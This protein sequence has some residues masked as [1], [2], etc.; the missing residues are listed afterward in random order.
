M[1]ATVPPRIQV[2]PPLRESWAAS[3]WAWGRTRAGS[4]GAPRMPGTVRSPPS[5]WCAEI[6]TS[7]G[8]APVSPPPRC[9][10]RA[11]PRSRS[12]GR[13][14]GT[15]RAHAT[16][17][18]W[19]PSASSGTA[20]RGCPR[21]APRASLHPVGHEALRVPLLRAVAVAGPD[22]PLPVR[23]EHGEAV[24]LGPEGHALEAF[25]VDPDHVEIEVASLG[26]VHVG[27]EEDP[28]PVGVEVG[29]EVGSAVVRHLAG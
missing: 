28:L 3:M 23:G 2:L 1:P 15:W 4:P 6:W 24:E 20:W 18:V 21:P 7:P 11:T 8:K 13:G 14:S 29:R 17:A 9:P 16:L 27:G 5:T 25:A 12:R 19:G 22:Q 26:V 10:G